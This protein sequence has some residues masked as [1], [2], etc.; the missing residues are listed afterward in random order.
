MLDNLL[1]INSTTYQWDAN[2]YEPYPSTKDKIA[3][4]FTAGSSAD[5]AAT[6][7]ATPDYI[8]VPFIVDKDGTIYQCYSTKY[9]AF[10]LGVKNAGKGEFDKVSIAIEIVNEGPLVQKND[11]LYWWPRN[12]NVRFCG[13]EDTDRYYKLSKPWRDYSYFTTYTA[14]QYDSLGKL[15]AYLC[16]MHDI[17]PTMIPGIGSELVTVEFLRAFKGIFTHHNIRADKTDCSPALNYD[18]LNTLI[19]AAYNYY[20]TNWSDI[21]KVIT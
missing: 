6:S 3:L 18:Y 10:H 2:D 20:R 7:L 14:A 9:W 17:P 21:P 13:L 1:N 11:G 4:H 8:S 12:F 16:V 19:Q 5:S 15:V